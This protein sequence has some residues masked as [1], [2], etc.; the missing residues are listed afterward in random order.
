MGRW[1]KPFPIRCGR[2]S[3][4]DN[5]KLVESEVNRLDLTYLACVEVSED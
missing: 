4:K 5:K 1:D 3:H 2:G